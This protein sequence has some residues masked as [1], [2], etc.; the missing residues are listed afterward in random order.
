MVKGKKIPVGF[1]KKEREKLINEVC[2][3]FEYIEWLYS[4]ALIH[5]SFSNDEWDYNTGVI[6]DFDKRNAK[7]ISLLYSGINDYAY[8]NHI[9]PISTE[10]GKFYRIIYRDC[11]FEIGFQ[12]TQGTFCYCKKVLISNDIDYINF[13]DIILYN[14]C[15]NAAGIDNMLQIFPQIVRNVHNSGVP[16][17]LLSEVFNKTVDEIKK[18]KIKTLKKY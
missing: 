2:S 10:Y 5:N 8:N 16:L 17:E 6:S 15:K 12:S 14:K 1:L 18:E 7:L 11:A 13:E 3:N 9:I 4:F